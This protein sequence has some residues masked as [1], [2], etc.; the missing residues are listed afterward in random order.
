MRVQNPILSWKSHS[1]NE[2]PRIRDWWGHFGDEGAKNKEN[3]IFF[4]KLII[5]VDIDLLFELNLAIICSVCLNALQI[6]HE[7]A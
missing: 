6:V 2:G 3:I 4:I 5:I 7:K 1:G